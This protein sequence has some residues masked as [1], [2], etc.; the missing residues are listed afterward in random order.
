MMF[1]AFRALP[2][3]I[4]RQFFHPDAT[5]YTL[6]AQFG[7]A[8]EDVSIPGPEGSRLHGWWMPAAGS[9]RGTVLHLHGNAGNISAHLPLV[10]WLPHAGFNLLTVDYRGFGRSDGAASLNGIV[11]DA[12]AALQWLRARPGVDPQRLVVLGQSLGGATAARLVGRDPGGVKLLVL[13]C[14]FASYR[15]VALDAVRGTWLAA[16]APAAVQALPDAA[17]DPVTAVRTLRVPLLVMHSENDAVVPI[18]H[19]RTLYAAAP[20]PKQWLELQHL[21]HVDGLAH[22]AVRRQVTAAMLQALR[23]D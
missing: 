8:A 13:D 21:Q 19:G 1:S 6:P 4:E 10:A 11:D 9:A 7:L 17:A 14:A 12:Q 3:V 2:S 16:L 18:S 15:G 23:A 22:E 5:V 20:E